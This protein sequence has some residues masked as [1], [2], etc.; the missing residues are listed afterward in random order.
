MG[1]ISCISR[2]LLGGTELGGQVQMP[3]QFVAL[4]APNFGMGT[5]NL[6]DAAWLFR[7]GR[8]P[9]FFLSV[10]SFNCALRSFGKIVSRRDLVSAISLSSLRV[11]S[12]LLRSIALVTAYA[13]LLAIVDIPRKTN[14]PIIV[15][16][17]FSTSERK[18]NSLF[19]GLKRC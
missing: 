2:S 9:F 19:N 15:Q 5:L 7:R 6:F 16:S 14:I 18:W 11:G 4:P 13:C 8:L 12:I 3:H 1:A 17:N 10:S